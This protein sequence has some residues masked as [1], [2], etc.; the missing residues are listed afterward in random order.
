MV[1]GVRFQLGLKQMLLNPDESEE[2]TICL[3]IPGPGKAGSTQLFGG[4]FTSV[5]FSGSQPYSRLVA[6]RTTFEKNRSARHGAALTTARAKRGWR[7]SSGGIGGLV[8]HPK[9]SEG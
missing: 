7:E 2:E 9:G 6:R 1:V 4:I 3:D 8:L 5:G